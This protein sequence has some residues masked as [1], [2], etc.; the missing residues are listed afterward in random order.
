[1][2]AKGLIK[3][4]EDISFQ[5]PLQNCQV[6]LF[7]RPPAW[8]NSALSGPILMKFHIQP[9]SKICRENPSFIKI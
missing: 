6:C 1:M 2:S 4:N 8:N 7:V 3:F 9:F 5:G